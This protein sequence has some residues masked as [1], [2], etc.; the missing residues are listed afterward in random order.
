M[1][2]AVAR[3]TFPGFVGELGAQLPQ[4][5]ST[6]PSSPIRQLRVDADDHRLKTPEGGLDV[7]DILLQAVETRV[8]RFAHAASSN[9]RKRLR[10]LVIAEFPARCRDMDHGQYSVAGR[11]L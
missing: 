10:Q 11:A 9:A 5:S 3:K 6:R 2:I 7:A 1:P 8:S 4:F